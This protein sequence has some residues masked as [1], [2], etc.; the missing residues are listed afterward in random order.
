LEI[1]KFVVG[2]PFLTLFE[3]VLSKTG[4]TNKGVIRYK[5]LLY[6]LT[7]FKRLKLYLMKKECYLLDAD[8]TKENFSFFSE[9]P[10]GRSKRRS[11]FK[12]LNKTF[13]IFH[14]RNEIKLIY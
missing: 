2:A 4:N 13:L 14:A 1:I 5:H 11:N 7:A 3:I 9:G 6:T 12:G 8:E 10:K